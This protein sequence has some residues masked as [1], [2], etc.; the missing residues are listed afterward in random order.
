MSIIAQTLG[1]QR[2]ITPPP[3]KKYPDADIKLEGPLTASGDMKEPHTI[4]KPDDLQPADLVCPFIVALV[5]RG[6]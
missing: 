2:R 1:T 6:Q 5:T 3:L 4:S